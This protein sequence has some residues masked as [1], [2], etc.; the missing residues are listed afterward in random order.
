MT[1]T[2]TLT[3]AHTPTPRTVLTPV[4]ALTALAA[5]LAGCSG[6]D[7]TP[8]SDPSGTSAGASAS[9]AADPVRLVTTSTIRAVTGGR[10]PQAERAPLR[11]RV[12]AVVDDWFDAAYLGGTYPR[13]DFGD[14]FGSFTAGARARAVEDR[15]LMSNAAV[16]TTTYAVRAL[17]R[18]VQIDVLA[19]GGRPSA[20]TV[21]F[22]LG[23]ARAGESGAELSERVSGHLYLTRDPGAGWQVFGYDVQRGVLA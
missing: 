12:T 8:A 7:P 23:M 10:L 9:T 11:D 16:G 6:D 4:V 13:T 22:R 1:P 19:V 18:R 20:V 5:L 2:P 21:Q 14:A 3:P 17:A 15:K